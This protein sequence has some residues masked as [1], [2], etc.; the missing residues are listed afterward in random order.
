MHFIIYMKIY[1]FYKYYFSGGRGSGGNRGS[2][3]GRGNFQ[4][5]NATYINDNRNSYSGHGDSGHQSSNFTLNS[6]GYGGQGG[7]QGGGYG[8]GYGLSLIHI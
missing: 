1:A 4:N 8:G 3:R 6:G 2:G 7:K 5:S